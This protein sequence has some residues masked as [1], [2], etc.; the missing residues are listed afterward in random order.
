MA[1]LENKQLGDCQ[2]VFGI[3]DGRCTVPCLKVE[4]FSMEETPEFETEATDNDGNV[5]SVVRGP[6][7]FTANISGYC[8]AADLDC[9]A[10]QIII[11]GK[12]G[13]QFY[14]EK[15]SISGS[16]NDFK[17]AEIT[18]HRYPGATICCS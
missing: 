4:S 5:A 18:A 11:P 1:C 13:G 7:K 10:C 17:K 3:S 6:S 8:T 2:Y 16:N 9:L 15:F 14:V 12:N